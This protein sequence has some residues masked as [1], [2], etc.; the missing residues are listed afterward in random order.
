MMTL[1]HEIIEFQQGASTPPSGDCF[2]QTCPG[3]WLCGNA[4][5]L[6]HLDGPASS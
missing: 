6:Q 3:K 4:G 1:M 5:M 2:L